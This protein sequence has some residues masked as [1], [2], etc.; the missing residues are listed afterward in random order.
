MSV[1]IKNGRIVTASEDFES[2]TIAAA[3][4][5]ELLRGEPTR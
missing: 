4:V 1:L 5:G 2:G 3:H